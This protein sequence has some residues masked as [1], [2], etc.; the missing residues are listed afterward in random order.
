M[1]IDLDEDTPYKGPYGNA[2]ERECF[3]VEVK[4]PH[5]DVRSGSGGVGAD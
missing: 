1:E 2:L 3:R 5:Y 4:D